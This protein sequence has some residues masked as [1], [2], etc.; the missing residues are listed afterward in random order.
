[1]E[2][3]SNQMKGR[4]QL[5]QSSG[6]NQRPKGVRMPCLTISVVLRSPS[7]TQIGSFYTAGKTV[8]WGLRSHSFACREAL[9]QL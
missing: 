3:S 5:G 2:V 6:W 9:A 8:F 4:A 7:F 1:M